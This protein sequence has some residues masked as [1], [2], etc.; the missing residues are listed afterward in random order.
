MKIVSRDVASLKPAPY[1]PRV[2]LKP[3]DKEY[4]EIRSS[5]E[6]YGLVVPLVFSKRGYVIGGAQRL[7]VIKDL[8]WKKVDTVDAPDM[9]LVMEK[10][11]NLALNKIDGKWD[12]ERLAQ[13]KREGVFT[14]FPT[15]FSS[16]EVE[17]IGKQAQLPTPKPVAVDVGSLPK[18]YQVVINCKDQKQQDSVI[19]FA[20][21]K[22]WE[23]RGVIL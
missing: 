4:E 10:A 1:N 18:I 2:A 12:P 19:G 11:L 14:K 17:A 7:T 15:G 23:A 6:T 9:T 20:K 8:G 5:L 3:G 22:G 13:L 16:A 21:E